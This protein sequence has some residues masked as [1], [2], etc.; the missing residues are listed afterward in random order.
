MTDKWLTLEQGAQIVGVSVSTLIRAVHEDRLKLEP[1]NGRYGVRQSVVLSAPLLT[2]GR[3]AKRI[4]VS[5]AAMRD[6]VVNKFIIPG[7][8]KAKVQGEEI[9]TCGAYYVAI[10]YLLALSAA[11][12]VMAEAEA[13]WE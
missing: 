12:E 5:Y 11:R 2:L 6:C 3:A 9:I 10:D 4:G 7:H 8:I 13:H 1:I